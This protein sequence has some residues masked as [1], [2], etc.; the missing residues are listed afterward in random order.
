LQSCHEDCLTM[1]IEIAVYEST[2]KVYTQ[3]LSRLICSL[4]SSRPRRNIKRDF[5]R[6]AQREDSPR[7]ILFCSLLLDKRIKAWGRGC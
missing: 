5:T 7:A 4:V 1:L 2:P 3:K 6:R